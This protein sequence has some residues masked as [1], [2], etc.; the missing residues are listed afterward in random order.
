MARPRV[1]VSSTFYD[2]KQVRE[3][4]RRFI[5]DLGYE[6]VLHEAGDIA[7]GIEGPPQ[8]YVHREIELCDILICVIGGRYGTESHEDPGSSI[9]RLELATAIENQVQVFI[10]VEQS[11][12]S[13]YYTFL[14]NKETPD[15]KYGYVDDVRVYKFIEEVYN[16]PANNPITS[17][18]TASD[19]TE[20]LRNQLAGLFHRFLQEQTRLEEFKALEEMK[21]ITGTLGQLVGLLTEDRENNDDA[22]QQILLAN[23]PAF[24]RFQDLTNTPYRVY[25][26]SKDE[27]NRWLQV[28]SWKPLSESAYDRGS[29]LEWI[30]TAEGDDRYIVLLEPIFDDD[31]RLKIYTADMW[32]DDWVQ[33]RVM[34]YEETSSNSSD[35]P[36]E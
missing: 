35:L 22:V 4:I 20:F 24:H 6:A 16:L 19:I 34:E 3:D 11:V 10:F 2:L 25:F 1:F 29:Q 15:I 8:D 30:A 17:F 28:R 7:Y 9:T 26:S 14:K 12:H 36:F 5:L 27:L 13:E 21:S 23:H 18:R 31:G 32:N 33:M